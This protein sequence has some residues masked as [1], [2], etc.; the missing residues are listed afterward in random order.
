L[1]RTVQHSARRL[2]E[3]LLYFVVDDS[4]PVVGPG[5]PLGVPGLLTLQKPNT[6][7]SQRDHRVVVNSSSVAHNLSGARATPHFD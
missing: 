4:Y 6:P 7:S 3:H 2:A 5:A 1:E